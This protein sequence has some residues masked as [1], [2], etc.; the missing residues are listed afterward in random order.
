MIKKLANVVLSIAITMIVILMIASAIVALEG[1][2]VVYPFQ[3]IYTDAN[4]NCFSL[5]NREYPYAVL[6]GT[7]FVEEVPVPDYIKKE[8][9]IAL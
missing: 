7:V 4:G 9:L 3:E 2:D 5:Y 1:N 8:E 6:C